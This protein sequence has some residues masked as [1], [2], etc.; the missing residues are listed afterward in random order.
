M[1]VNT[2]F[3]KWPCVLLS[4]VRVYELSENKIGVT[5][6]NVWR[7]KWQSVVGCLSSLLSKV[8]KIVQNILSLSGASS[9][10]SWNAVWGDKSVDG[11]VTGWKASKNFWCRVQNSQ[12]Q[13]GNNLS[14]HLLTLTRRHRF[15]SSS[16]SP[17]T[18]FTSSLLP[19]S[20][21]YSRL[22]SFST[23]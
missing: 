16:S 7:E 6:V 2:H 5:S 23:S 11:L 8:D 9:N 3:Q 21:L 20:S 17:S 4:L 15:L 18:L 12:Q 13:N 19:S 22:S 1:L 14:A 10:R